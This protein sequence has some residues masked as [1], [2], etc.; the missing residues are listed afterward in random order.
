MTG[1]TTMARTFIKFELTNPD[2]DADEDRRETHFEVSQK[3]GIDQVGS[4]SDHDGASWTFISSEI[5]NRRSFNDQTV[6][7]IEEIFGWTLKE[8]S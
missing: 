6:T 5:K 3:G 1:P 4:G 2:A 7:K 8:V